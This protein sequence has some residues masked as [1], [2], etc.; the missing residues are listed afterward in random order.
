MNLPTSYPGV[1]VMV[2]KRAD[3]Q[4]EL[5]PSTPRWA[6]ANGT[7]VLLAVC[8][9]EVA[10]YGSVNLTAAAVP[11]LL[12]PPSTDRGDER[13]VQGMPCLDPLAPLLHRYLLPPP[14]PLLFLGI[15]GD[16][17]N[18]FIFLFLNFFCRFFFSFT[19]NDV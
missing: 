3:S 14:P 9:D 17:F 6:V 19:P 11:A 5:L 15:F 7:A 10:R 8:E 2:G 18:S 12:L 13:L 16:F 1:T 4:P